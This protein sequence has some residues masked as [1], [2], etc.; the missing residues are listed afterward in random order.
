MLVT[1]LISIGLSI[2]KSFKYHINYD[3]S[4]L[5]YPFIIEAD[6]QTNKGWVRDLYLVANFVSDMLNYVVFVLTN[7]SIDF[8]MLFRLRKTLKEKLDR[9]KLDRAQSKSN[10]KKKEDVKEALNNAVRMVIINSALNFFLKLPLVYIPLQNMIATFFYKT[11]VFSDN[12][13]LLSLNS[14]LNFH[15]Y[16]LNMTEMDLITLISEF[17]DWLYN[18][19]ISLQFFV[20][21]KFNKK[22]KEA[23]DITFH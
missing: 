8:Y 1:A 4:E 7:I 9:F 23:Y 22:L 18:L 2:V 20:Y 17:S 19:L 5:N 16:L 15:V 11:K 10:K 6:F 14:D 12:G 21:L 13:E 3:H